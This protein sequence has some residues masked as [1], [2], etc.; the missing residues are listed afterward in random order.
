MK[1]SF[2]K[3]NKG[4][5]LA[6]MIIALAIIVFLVGFAG[7]Q[8]V[9]YIEKSKLSKDVSNAKT[10]YSDVV[11]T[12]G[13][14]QIHDELLIAI[15]PGYANPPG[16]ILDFTALPGA[17]FTGTAGHALS[18]LNQYR[19]NAPEFNYNKNNPSSWVVSVEDIGNYELAAHVYIVDGTGAR[20]EVAPNV[21]G[22]YADVE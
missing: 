5:S 10:I 19:P 4:F 3:S 22:P 14:A 7:V 21:T 6:E 20:I 1:N 2:I 17:A 18:T 13:E 16:G 15:N 8:L 12:I 9:R 11:T